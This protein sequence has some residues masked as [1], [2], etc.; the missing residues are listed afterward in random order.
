M[1]PVA[2]GLDRPT[3]LEIIGYQA[4]VVTLTGDVW[5]IALG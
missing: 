1:T 4:Y 3:S 5:R 2:V